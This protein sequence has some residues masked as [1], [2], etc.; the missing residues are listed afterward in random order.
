VVEEEEESTDTNPLQL[1]TKV[2][3]FPEVSAEVEEEKGTITVH[4][5]T[6]EHL[7][8]LVSIPDKNGKMV[9][10]KGPFDTGSQLSFLN[11]HFL[12]EYLPEVLLCAV[13]C[14]YRVRGAGGERLKV[15]GQAEVSCKVEGRPVNQTFVIADIAEDV[16]LGLDFIA[17]HK[18][19]WNWRVNRMEFPAERE[20]TCL[21]GVTEVAT[22]AVT[23]LRIQTDDLKCGQ[24]VHRHRYYPMD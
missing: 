15:L 21:A 17:R 18:A 10:V 9:H 1:E 19:N 5:T 3:L 24:L 4:F 14:P 23:T 2:L 22:E 13:T 8:M 7:H 11:E 6:E 20:E 12:R 16:L